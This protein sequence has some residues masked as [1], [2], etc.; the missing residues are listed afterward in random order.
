MVIDVYKGIYGVP[1]KCGSRFFLKAAP[2]LG[3]PERRSFREFYSK[4]FTLEWIV[5]RNPLEHLKSALQTEVMECFDDDSAIL[6][7]LQSFQDSY[8][9]GSH[10]Y[11][12][13]CQKIYEVWYK[14]RYKL[15]VIDLSQLSKFMEE[16]LH[17]IPYDETEFD[18][19]WS[20]NYKT[21]NE[22]WDRCIKLDKK[23]METLIQYA[24]NDVEYYNALLNKDDSFVKW[25]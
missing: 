19:H 17:H 13:F 25:I 3:E 10:F 23:S 20:T 22:I 16:I 5:I 1:T 6:Q 9:G 11:P 4:K 14:N 8:N 15:K 7:I 2:Y 12:Q 21:K 18:F 24:T